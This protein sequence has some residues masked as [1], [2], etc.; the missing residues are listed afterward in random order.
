ME[1][2]LVVTLETA[3]KLKAAGFEQDDIYLHW[4]LKDEEGDTP[5]NPWLVNVNERTED[6]Y[7]ETIA[8]PTAQEIADQLPEGVRVVKQF[9]STYH[10]DTYMTEED[11][12]T[13]SAPGPTMAEALAALW[14]KLQE[15]K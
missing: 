2:S 7:E 14:L 15:V 6:D 5:V 13:H 3:Q 1:E 9:G 10:A 8:A 12:P 4:L 11:A